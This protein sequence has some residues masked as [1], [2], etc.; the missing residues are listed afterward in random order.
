MIIWWILFGHWE[1]QCKHQTRYP[2]RYLYSRSQVQTFII[3]QVFI[4]WKKTL[5]CIY[6]KVERIQMQ[7]LKTYFLALTIKQ[8]LKLVTNEYH[9]NFTHRG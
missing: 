3:K 9:S 8:N 5:C 2:A 4:L 1:V 6:F 7:E